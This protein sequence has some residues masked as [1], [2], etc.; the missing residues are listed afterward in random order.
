MVASMIIYDKSTAELMMTGMV[1]GALDVAGFNLDYDMDYGDN[2]IEIIRK[3][4]GVKFR[5]TIEYVTGADEPKAL[6]G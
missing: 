4:N 3:T 2:T 1:A 6:T 5:I